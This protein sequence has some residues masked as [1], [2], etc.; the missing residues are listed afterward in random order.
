[1]FNYLTL[2]CS[3]I[4]LASAYVSEL[5]KFPYPELVLEAPMPHTYTKEEDLPKV[6][7]WSNMDGTT[8]I[9]KALNQHVPQYCGSC[10]AQ[11]AVSVLGDRIKIQ[12]I[13]NGTYKGQDINLSVQFILNCGTDRAGSC[14]GGDSLAAWAFIKSYGSIPYDSCLPYE[15]CS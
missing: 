14:H 8:Y 9:T 10:W 7:D 1:M 3:T 5:K 6:W 11:A 15:S 2:L 4:S 13:K 12:R